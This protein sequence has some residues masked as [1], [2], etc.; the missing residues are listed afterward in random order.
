MLSKNDDIKKVEITLHTDNGV[1]TYTPEDYVILFEGEFDGDIGLIG[2]ADI[3]KV[4]AAKLFV[5]KLMEIVQGITDSI[6]KEELKRPNIIKSVIWA[7]P[8]FANNDLEGLRKNENYNK[9]DKD[10]ISV[11]EELI[12]ENQ[13]GDK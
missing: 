11:I 12:I 3:K 13:K 8:Y 1:Y 7:F 4:K 9:T 10:I 2:S 5:C 6:E